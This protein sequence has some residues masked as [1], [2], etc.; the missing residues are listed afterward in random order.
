MC[1]IESNSSILGLVKNLRE[2]VK[3]DKRDCQKEVLELFKSIFN[4]IDIH[5]DTPSINKS[6]NDLEVQVSDLEAKLLTITMERDNLLGTINDMRNEISQF[7]ATFSPT[8]QIAPLSIEPEQDEKFSPRIQG[9]KSLGDDGAKKPVAMNING[10]RIRKGGDEQKEQNV[11]IKR[12]LT[13]SNN[14]VKVESA[15]NVREIDYLV[16]GREASQT[17]NLIHKLIKEG[18]GNVKNE[19]QHWDPDY[20]P[21]LEDAPG[22]KLNNYK[23]KECRFAF[24]SKH[25]LDRHIK[26]VHEKTTNYQC[27]ECEYASARKDGLDRHIKAVHEKS[28]NYQCNECEYATYRSDRLSRHYVNVHK[29][30]QGGAKV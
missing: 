26:S 16:S 1:S 8:V 3:R 30:N 22:K 29:H 12:P 17:K 18:F 24:V 21:D 5:T 28:K 7:S 10:K 25:K 4:A 19:T 27:K 13:D 15:G 9:I 11:K 2:E 20:K 14:S 23:C 6:L